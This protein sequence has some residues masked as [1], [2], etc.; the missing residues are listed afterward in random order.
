MLIPA[1]LFAGFAAL[2]LVWGAILGERGQSNAE[3]AAGDLAILFGVCFALTAV[4][5]TLATALGDF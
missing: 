1:A 2:L 5:L 3:R 4:A